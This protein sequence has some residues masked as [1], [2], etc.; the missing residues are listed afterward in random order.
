MDGHEIDEFRRN[1]RGSTDQI[2]FI[3]PILVI[4]HNDQLTLTDRLNGIFHSIE[5]HDSL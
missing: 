1:G 5:G 2:A 3:F 4:R